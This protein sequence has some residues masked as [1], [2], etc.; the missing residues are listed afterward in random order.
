MKRAMLD[1]VELEYDVHG[2][3][4][5]VV[6]IHPGIFA[7]WFE[8]VLRESQLANRHTLLWYSRAGCAGSSRLSGPVSIADH[9][10]HARLLMQHLGIARAHV[11]GHSSSACVALQLALDA[12]ELL[13]SLA[14]LEPALMTVPSSVTSRVAIGEA[15]QRYKAGDRTGAIDTFLRCVCGPD[16]RPVLD[17]A[18]PGGFEQYV[19]DASTFFEQEFAA[20]QQ[21]SFGREAARRI[22]Q[23]VLAVVGERSLRYDPIWGERQQLLLEWLP[24]VEPFVL[25]SAAHLLQIENPA[26]MAK[27]LADFFA[28]HSSAAQA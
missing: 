3:G 21:W 14:V 8:P 27:G 2:E 13:Q 7:D 23:P 10:T 24:H 5:H 26:G 6:L 12:S 15:V 16:Y 18:L 17:R 19:A 28:R 20:V 1:G 22:T 25:P 4:E 11:V 9:A